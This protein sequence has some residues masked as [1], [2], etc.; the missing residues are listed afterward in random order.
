MI[1]VADAALQ[2]AAQKGMD[3][4]IKVFIDAYQEALGG[5]PS[6]ENMHLLTGEQHSL[7][8][9]Y[10]LRQ[11]LMDGG[12]CQLIQNG[13]GGY[14]FDNPF[15]KAMRLWGAKEFSKLIYSAKE[16]FDANRQDL[17]R[18]RTDDEFMAM[19]EQYEAFDD[20]EETFMETEELITT[21]IAS[22]VDE[23]INLFAN[24][25]K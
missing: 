7:L 4:F 11:E 5:D 10:I 2:K 13:Y 25:K 16:I 24:V 23:N 6:A 18:E 22:Y 19:Y 12:F 1:E 15:A 9:Y 14:I 3:E 21:I 8:S 20:L 17:E